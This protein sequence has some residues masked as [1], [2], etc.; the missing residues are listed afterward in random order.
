LLSIDW[1]LE[2]LYPNAAGVRH[3]LR[4]WLKDRHFNRSYRGRYAGSRFHKGQLRRFTDRDRRNNTKWEADMARR[5]FAVHRVV[6][7]YAQAYMDCS[8]PERDLWLLK[9]CQPAGGKWVGSQ[10]YRN[11]LTGCRCQHYLCPW[12]YLRKFQSIKNLIIFEKGA[13]VKYAHSGYIGEGLGFK[14]KVSLTLFEMRGDE[15]MLSQAVHD[16]FRK[17]ADAFLLRPLYLKN[18]DETLAPV[19]RKEPEFHV[20]MRLYSLGFEDDK[21]VARL[22]YIHNG[23]QL[24]PRFVNGANHLLGNIEI[25]RFP[26]LHV[27][28]AIAKAFIFPVDLFTCVNEGFEIVKAMHRRRRFSV[29]R[30]ET[31]KEET[32]LAEPYLFDEWMAEVLANTTKLGYWDWILAKKKVLE[33]EGQQQELKTSESLTS[34]EEHHGS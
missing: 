3:C 33:S 2:E 32:G 30:Y 18:D 23:D 10:F 29:V 5:L 11:S 1:S 26:R 25:H 34:E 12:C 6:L 13:K 15:T 9:N 17:R 24:L 31:G 8:K 22:G 21:Y 14:D 16:Y 28:L 19:R 27:N 7:E 20:G 4:E